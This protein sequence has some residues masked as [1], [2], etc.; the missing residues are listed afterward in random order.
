MD[1]LWLIWQ[2]GFDFVITFSDG[3]P[4]WPVAAQSYGWAREGLPLKT[5]IFESSELETQQSYGDL[6]Y[7]CGPIV[8][9]CSAICCMWLVTACSAVNVKT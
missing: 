4:V 8:L 7:V 1:D 2:R 3:K 5:L 9:K 6:N